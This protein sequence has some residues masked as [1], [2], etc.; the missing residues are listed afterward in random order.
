MVRDTIPILPEHTGAR[1]LEVCPESFF[2]HK[3][4]RSSLK[5]AQILN[6]D[7]YIYTNCLHHGSLV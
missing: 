4:M 6:L 5:A 3:F 1:F 7:G 2:E